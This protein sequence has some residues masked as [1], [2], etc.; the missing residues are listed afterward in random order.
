MFGTSINASELYRGLTQRLNQAADAGISPDDS[1]D[2]VALF[3]ANLM[4]QMQSRAAV[5]K[6]QT[7]TAIYLVEFTK[8]SGN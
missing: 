7:K 4:I 5:D 1:I 3:I 8:A 6:L 2:G